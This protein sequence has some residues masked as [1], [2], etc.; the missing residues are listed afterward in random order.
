MCV[1]ERW[2]Y[3]ECGCQIDHSVPCPAFLSSTS[4]RA[5]SPLRRM[6]KQSTL[7]YQYDSSPG[8]LPPSP[9]T[10]DSESEA[11]LEDYYRKAPSTRTCSTTHTVD[12]TFLEPICDDCLLE[13][14][15]IERPSS[16]S[17]P[18]LDGQQAETLVWNSDVKIEV[19]PQQIGKGHNRQI[20]CATIL[21]SDVQIQIEDA[22]SDTLSELGQVAS[23][24]LRQDSAFSGADADDEG[25]INV[26]RGRSRS[27][28][29]ELRRHAM[30]VSREDLR[31]RISSRWPSIVKQ[32]MQVF[33]DMLQGRSP[34]PAKPTVPPSEE[35][36]S[37]SKTTLL[38]D[39]EIPTKTALSR[40]TQ[41]Q[42]GGKTWAK[43][44]IGDLKR[45]LSRNSR[46]GKK[47]T[48]R[49]TSDIEIPP[50]P[51][52]PATGSTIRTLRAVANESST[53]LSRFASEPTYESD[54]GVN[55][56]STS[57]ASWQQHLSHDLSSRPNARKTINRAPHLRLNNTQPSIRRTSSVPN[58]L[59][60]SRPFSDSQRRLLSNSTTPS[61][62]TTARS[63]SSEIV[64]E[65]HRLASLVSDSDFDQAPGSWAYQSSPIPDPTTQS[66]HL[67][68]K[69]EACP[70]PTIR[71]NR[72]T[73]QP[74]PATTPPRPQSRLAVHPLTTPLRTLTPQ[75]PQLTPRTSSLGF[76]PLSA[77]IRFG[78][79]DT[80]SGI[81][82]SP[83]MRYACIWERDLCGSCGDVVGGDAR[84]ESCV[85]DGTLKHAEEPMSG[86]Q[87]HDGRKLRC[88]A[89]APIVRY[90]SSAQKREEGQ[91]GQMLEGD[92][93]EGGVGL[94][95][96]CEK[97]EAK[98]LDGDVRVSRLGFREQSA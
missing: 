33:K 29:K 8:K 89:T 98:A 28:T 4:A 46:R 5:T 42:S 48:A 47:S 93:G 77:P 60:P 40:F 61:I 6:P 65:P 68:E 76:P 90:V 69:Q 96:W 9:S 39:G 18:P 35:T 16:N 30:D 21:E 41:G 72:S 50:L 86:T 78:S 95:T 67:S 56:S 74:P 14:L 22:V 17:L 11:Q 15:G 36:A 55:H 83:T 71:D 37:A 97:C 66:Y 75:R 73:T 64:S 62:P 82:H 70:S 25:S 20:S 80:I 23:P 57:I 27:R 7:R 85:C 59:I 32:D 92:E 45:S 79:Q 24:V 19:E 1:H 81:K 3:S 10:T 2:A 51:S 31:L 52:T 26:P 58:W 54:Y 94:S 53:T 43:N 44:V 84:V 38:S 49:G 13:E 12:K 91:P 88:R 63:L 87:A 34:S